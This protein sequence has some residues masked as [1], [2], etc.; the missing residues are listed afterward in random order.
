MA[1]CETLTYLR[2][3]KGLSQEQLA[4]ELDITRQTISK[5]ELNQSTPDID[6]LLRLSE[7]FEVSTDYLLKGRL[8]EDMKKS[9]DTNGVKVVE[10]KRVVYIWCFCLDAIITGISL[11]GIIAFVILSALHPWIVEV[12]DMVYEGLLGFLK[13]T[14]TLWFFVVLSILFVVGGFSTWYS[15]MKLAGIKCGEIKIVILRCLKLREKKRI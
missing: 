7:Y 13:G 8:D 5:W 9:S 10:R 3:L 15:L 2:K 11:M 6:Y 14:H 1:F 4:Q 12:N